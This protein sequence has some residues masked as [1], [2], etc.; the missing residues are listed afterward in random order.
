MSVPQLKVGCV[1]HWEQYEFGDGEK[2]DK[3]F[4]VLGAKPK[5]NL[6]A[7]IAT[8]RPHKRSFTPGCH[9]KDGYFHIPGD[10]GE[11]FWKDTWLLLEP[12]ELTLGVFLKVAFVDKC[13]TLKA[14]LSG[15]LANAI[16]NCLKRC[17]D[18]SEAQLRLL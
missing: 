17:L 1:F 9:H 2:A 6:L 5:N 10:Q 7:V 12:I 18:V 3:F 15:D 14:E 13:I 16:R 11:F 4:V 8:S